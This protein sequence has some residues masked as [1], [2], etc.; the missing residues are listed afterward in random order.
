MSKRDLKLDLLQIPA[1]ANSDR[2]SIK[3]QDKSRVSKHFS[4]HH[5]LRASQKEQSERLEE[6]SE[7]LVVDLLV[8]QQQDT[9]QF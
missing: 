9:N 6:L 4:Q 8:S 1:G 2:S 7:E 3:K 5:K